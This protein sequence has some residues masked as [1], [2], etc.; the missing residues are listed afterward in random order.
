[1]PRLSW[2]TLALLWKIAALIGSLVTQAAAT[3]TTPPQIEM[4]FFHGQNCPP[5]RQMVPIVEALQKANW[6][7]VDVNTDDGNAMTTANHVTVIPTFIIKINGLEI[8]RKT[9]AMTMGD[10][11][12]FYRGSAATKEAPPSEAAQTPPTPWLGLF[13][14]ALKF[15]GAMVQWSEPNAF[16]EQLAKEHANYMASVCVQGHQGWDSRSARVMQ[17]GLGSTAA[18]IAAE[19]WEWQRNDSMND[20]GWEMFKC[21]RQSS[22][23]WECASRQHRYWGGWMA[24]G[25]N[26][27]WYAD[28]IVAD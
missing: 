2:N 7:I 25:R 4:F 27:I 24:Q 9:G 23:H 5:C 3:E 8:D 15:P 22:G 1:M 14:A 10:L 26:G 21:W 28:I 11:V 17:S 13:H 12:R 18:E 16:L 6:P 19:S 20:L